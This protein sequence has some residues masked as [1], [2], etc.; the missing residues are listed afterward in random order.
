VLADA[1]KLRTSNQ[2]DARQQLL[3]DDVSQAYNKET[4][5]GQDSACHANKR[6]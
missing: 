3:A 6:A 5:L 1:Y 4:F 2:T